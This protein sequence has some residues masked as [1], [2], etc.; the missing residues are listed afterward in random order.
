MERFGYLFRFAGIF[1]FLITCIGWYKAPYSIFFSVAR[2]ATI[3]LF[4]LSLLTWL[5]GI[6]INRGK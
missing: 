1:A 5:A 4:S 3:L 2:I 6:V